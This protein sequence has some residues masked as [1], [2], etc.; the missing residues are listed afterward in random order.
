MVFSYRTAQVN[1]RK[2]MTGILR[3]ILREKSALVAVAGAL[4]MAFILQAPT[5]SE[6]RAGMDRGMTDQ[7]LL[8][9]EGAPERKDL[10]FLGIDEASLQMDVDE[11][12]LEG[13]EILAM[14]SRRFPWDR[15]VYA[16]MIERL[17]ESGARLVVIDLLMTEPSDPE[18]DEVLAEVLGR[19]RDRVILA[20]MFA[21][22]AS[23]EDQFMLSDPWEGFW[24]EGPEWTRSGYVNFRP[25][26]SDLLVRDATYTTTLSEENGLGKQEGEPVFR[27]LA[28]EVLDALG[29]PVPEGRRGLRFATR[30]GGDAHEV[31][32]PIPIREI[33]LPDEWKHRYESGEFFKDKVVMIGPAAPRF[34]DLHR[35]PV[36]LLMGPQLHL[37]AIGCGLENAFVRRPFESLRSRDFYLTIA[38]VISAWLAGL[39][40]KRP[41]VAWAGALGLVGA[42][43]AGAFILADAT[44]ILVGFSAWVLK[45]VVGLVSGQSY[46]LVASRLER[47]RLHR[48]F[49]RFVSRD[50]AD[51]LVEHPEIYR[52]AAAGRKRQVVVLF[53]DVRGFTGRSEREDPE[54]LV[55][56]LNEY[57][58]AMVAAVFQHSGTLDKFIGDAVMAHWGALVD[59]DDGV[60]AANAL[61]TAREMIDR[62]RELNAKW[63]EEGREPYH[64]GI[65][66][67]LGEAVAGEIGSAERTEFAVIGDAVNLASRLEGLTKMFQTELLASGTTVDAS[68]DRTGMRRLAKVRVKGRAEPVDVWGGSLGHAGDAGYAIALE[69]FESGDFSGARRMFADLAREYPEDGP[70]KAMEDWTQ[71]CWASPL[72]AWDGVLTM[73]EK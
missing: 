63:E 16:A 8:R 52:H 35:T 1:T 33:F 28:A 4:L 30:N 12:L 21:P 43:L 54:R 24:G 73:D 27:S 48:E 69:L 44:G 67:H 9:A 18:A 11:S 6:W 56:Q 61:K 2:S 68:G 60:N 62:V 59:G 47:G 13:N 45:F 39:W 15:R 23:G 22:L 37:Q 58:S 42:A 26:P 7:M 72:P 10:V 20:S 40:V 38:G 55:G 29:K 57:F 5:A 17:V 14:M 70:S 25:D 64:I 34:Q 41:Q 71:Q 31:Y 46:A 19:H 51:S 49:R 50:V 65:G 66:I 53:S 36:G 32:E 3:S